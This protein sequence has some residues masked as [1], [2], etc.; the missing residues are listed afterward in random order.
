MAPP[1]WNHSLPGKELV[2]KTTEWFVSRNV[3]A[4]AGIEP[5]FTP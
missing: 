1:R 2:R 3:V 4:P 5:A